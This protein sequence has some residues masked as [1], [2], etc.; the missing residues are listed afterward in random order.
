M[1][2]P[3]D[4]L[5]N[6]MGTFRSV[7]AYMIKVNPA[8]TWMPLMT[9][10]GIRLV[11]HSN[12][13]VM[14]RKPITPATKRPAEATSA[15]LK[16]LARATD[17][18][19]FIGCTGKGIP[20]AKPVKIFA[21]PEN[22]RVVDRDIAGTTFREDWLAKAIMIGSNVP[23]SP[24]E[25]EISLNGCRRK[26]SRLYW[27]ISRSCLRVSRTRLRAKVILPADASSIVLL[28]GPCVQNR[29][30][31]KLWLIE[32]SIEPEPLRR[33][34]LPRLIATMEQEIRNNRECNSGEPPHSP[35]LDVKS[36]AVKTLIRKR[37]KD[38]INRII[39]IFVVVL[40]FLFK[41]IITQY[42]SFVCV[43]NFMLFVIHC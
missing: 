5:V 1:I 27:E 11:N 19:A 39:Q 25:P 41:H 10:I 38:K 9:G 17:A 43:S 40:I 37:L 34:R 20:K 7:P 6:G 26:V 28:L 29:E 36:S 3:T 24:K 14:L 13:P 23:R 15:L 31:M 4:S 8:P 30:Y 32:S 33:L 12:N 22:T 42:E 2:Q 21:R 18:I 16:S 35:R